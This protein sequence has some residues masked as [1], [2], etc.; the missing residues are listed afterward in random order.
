MPFPLSIAF[1]L[2][3]QSSM[4]SAHA[5]S[6]GER[7]SDDPNKMICKRFVEIG[8]LVGTTRTCKT[9]ADWARDREEA[10]SQA[11]IDA[12]QA[13]SRSDSGGQTMSGGA[14]C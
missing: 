8:S 4:A 6:A 12:C 2:V 3:A 1:L 14:A 13:S 11:A 9:K 5:V 7:A 10:R